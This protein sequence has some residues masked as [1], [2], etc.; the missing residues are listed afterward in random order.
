MTPF[1]R[2]TSRHFNVRQFIDDAAVEVE[3][4]VEVMEND[5][6]KDTKQ[7]KPL[8]FCAIHLTNLTKHNSLWMMRVLLNLT[9][10]PITI[11]P[12]ALSVI[13]KLLRPCSKHRQLHNTMSLS[14]SLALKVNY[15]V[16]PSTRQ[17]N[18]ICTCTVSKCQ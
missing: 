9:F 7:S 13:R 14:V 6:D 8:H 1:F 18:E 11:P 16:F 2:Q 12:F 10:P 17:R 4:E 3:V 5:N 15:Q